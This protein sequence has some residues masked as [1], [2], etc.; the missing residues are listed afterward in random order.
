MKK[1]TI[2][3]GTNGSGKT[4][5]AKQMT[6]G[7]K[8]VFINSDQLRNGFAFK[9]VNIDT[10]VIVI[11][12]ISCFD[13]IYWLTGCDF[14]VINKQCLEPFEIRRPELI[15]TSNCFEESHFFMLPEL[16]VITCNHNHGN[17]PR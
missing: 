8:A 14:L 9:D 1:Q 17:T 11:E 4:Y 12:E 6:E 15:F 13:E 16:K 5:T 2:L 3:L 7:K 10:E